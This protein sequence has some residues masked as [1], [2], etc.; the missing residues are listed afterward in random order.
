MPALQTALRSDAFY[1]G[2]IG[3]RNT[4]SKRR[5]ALVAAG[6]TEDELGRIHGPAGLDLGASTP[7]ETAIAILSEALAVRS[8]RDGGRLKAAP[9]RIHVEA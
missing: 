2:A 4:Q 5:E 3:S 1:V 8:G 6:L 7:A 9:G